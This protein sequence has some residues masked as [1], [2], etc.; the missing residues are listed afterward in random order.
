MGKAPN[1]WTMIGCVLQAVTLSRGGPA[2]TSAWI[3]SSL[4]HLQGT[5][6]GQVLIL[7]CDLQHKTVGYKI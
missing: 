5:F 4:H 6:L 2:L 1:F 7:P 3:I